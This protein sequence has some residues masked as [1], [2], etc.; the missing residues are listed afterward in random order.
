MKHLSNYQ[1]IQTLTDR[2]KDAIIRETIS[3]LDYW[4][5]QVGWPNR[6]FAL[7]TFLDLK[8]LAIRLGLPGVRREVEYWENRELA[9][10]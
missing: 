4:Q 9:K 6:D 5:V 7:A 8:C 2:Q 3:E 1:V 10:L